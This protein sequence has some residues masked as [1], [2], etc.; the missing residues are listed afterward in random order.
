MHW[1]LLGTWV[2]NKIEHS[3]NAYDNR[4][5]REMGYWKKRFVVILMIAEGSGPYWAPQAQVC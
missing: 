1:K 3:L 2:I 4:S 5:D